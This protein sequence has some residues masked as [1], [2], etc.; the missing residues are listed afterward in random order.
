[1]K[2]YKVSEFKK[3]IQE[4]LS[5]YEPKIAQSVIK[6]NI[7][8]NN[9][10]YSQ[11]SKDSAKFQQ[12]FK[13]GGMHL[14]ENDYDEATNVDGLGMERIK[15]SYPLDKFTKE[16]LKAQMLGKDSAIQKDIDDESSAVDT[17]GNE[18]YLETDGVKGN[19]FDNAHRGLGSKNSAMIQM[20][21]NI[22]ALTDGTKPAVKHS[23]FTENTDKMKRL[24]FKQTIFSNEN[25]IFSLI[26][27]SYKID[28]NKFLMKDK[29]DNEY[30]IEWHINKNFN[31]GNATILEE[32]HDK[33]VQ[34]SINKFKHLSNYNSAA[35]MHETTSKT[36]VNEDKN[37]GILID[38]AKAIIND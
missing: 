12:G 22:F 20:G 27:E 23:A 11:I 6:A 15:Y 1:M 24:N 7:K 26:P 21:N 37:F 13:N 5:D 35:Q 2:T 30:L 34:E 25:H 18:A 4:S 36:R 28:N 14:E 32:K 29:N 17:K 3:I 31:A 19:E 38:K 10:S 16:R 9:D 33:I 8:N